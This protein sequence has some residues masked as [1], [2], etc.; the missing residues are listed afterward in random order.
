MNGKNLGRLDVLCEAPPVAIVE[1]CTLGEFVRPCDVAWRK[2]PVPGPNRCVCGRYCGDMT[3]Y[4]FECS[5]GFVRTFALLQCPKC[6]TI[7]W[8]RRGM[9]K[10]K[11]H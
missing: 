9:Q 5:D 4:Q 2:A 8:R 1:G 3:D 7:W 6:H 10:L 11:K